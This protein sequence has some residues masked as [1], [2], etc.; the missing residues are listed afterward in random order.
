MKQEW[1]HF[2]LIPLFHSGIYVSRTLNFEDFEVLFPK[3][4]VFPSGDTA[5]VPWN[6]FTV[7]TRHF[8][9]KDQQARSRSRH[10]DSNA[11]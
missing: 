1:F 2:P 10:P 9:P 7:G 3:E 6:S 4:E 8:E 11:T 5:K